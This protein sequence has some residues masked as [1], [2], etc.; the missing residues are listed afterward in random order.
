MTWGSSF[1]YALGFVGSFN[2]RNA[3][4]AA[5]IVSSVLQN[6]ILMKLSDTPSDTFSAEKNGLAGI[7]STPLSSAIHWQSAQ[8]FRA[9]EL[10]REIKLLKKSLLNDSNLCYI[11]FNM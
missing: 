8:S 7:H 10:I 4:D 3:A 2:K 1:G 11:I 6:A 9:T 5:S